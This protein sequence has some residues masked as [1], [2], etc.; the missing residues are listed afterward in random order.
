MKKF[1]YGS[2]LALAVTGGVAATAGPL[3]VGSA[4][5]AAVQIPAGHRVATLS[6]L[7]V[8]CA[9][10][11]PVVKRALSAIPGVSAVSV[12]EGSGVNATVR[13]AYDPRKVT[14]AALAAATSEAG[15]PAK[16]VK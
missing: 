7:N 1:L 10:C 13:V 4:A 2:A 3:L 6:V 11:A 8:G 16:V 15:Y 12:K 5:T 14:P 9:T